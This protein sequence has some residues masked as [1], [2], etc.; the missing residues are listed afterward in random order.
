VSI[1]FFPFCLKEK[2][3][4]GIFCRLNFFVCLL[5]LVVLLL[6]LLL[7]LVLMLFF[8][9]GKKLFMN[10]FNYVIDLFNIK[11]F[12]SPSNVFYCHYLVVVVVDNAVDVI[13]A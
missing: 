4:Q 8:S 11:V 2:A 9:E 13:D 7:L 6:L 1:R 12:F 3:L 10:E 5:L